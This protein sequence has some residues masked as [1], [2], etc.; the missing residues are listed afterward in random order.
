MTVIEEADIG[1]HSKRMLR[2]RDILT[3]ESLAD[4]TSEEVRSWMGMGPTR[5]RQLAAA[6]KGSGLSFAA[7]PGSSGEPVHG[8]VRLRNSDTQARLR[9]E[10]RVSAVRAGG[11]DPKALRRAR[12][13]FGLTQRAVAD[14]LRVET[15]VIRRWETGA[16]QP[17]ATNLLR[18]MLLFSLRPRQLLRE[19]ASEEREGDALP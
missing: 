1:A 17:S 13:A 11:F 16:S 18:L 5:F 8:D 3:L 15:D 7:A 4:R 10:R 2:V 9:Q 19:T 12:K 14:V 6:L